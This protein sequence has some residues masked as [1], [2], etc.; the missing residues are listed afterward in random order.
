MP[1]RLVSHLKGDLANP[2]P[3]DFGAPAFAG[4][5]ERLGDQHAARAAGRAAAAGELLRAAVIGEQH[6]RERHTVVK[7]QEALRTGKAR[8]GIAAVEGEKF[9]DRKAFGRLAIDAAAVVVRASL[10]DAVN[11]L[12]HMMW[13]L[14]SRILQPASSACADRGFSTKI[15]RSPSIR[16]VFYR[17]TGPVTV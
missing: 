9:A 13:I 10:P 1:Q 15:Y 16:I 3:V 12:V 11:Q 14:S 17:R 5:L 6:V 7:H 2:L 8:H 4:C